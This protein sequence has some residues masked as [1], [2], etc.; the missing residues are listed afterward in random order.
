MKFKNFIQ[1][2]LNE[3]LDNISFRVKLDAKKRGLKHQSHNI[4]K[5]QVG[6]KFKWVEQTKKFELIQKKNVK[7]S[8]SKATELLGLTSPKTLQQNAELAKDK[9]SNMTPNTPLKYKVA[10]QIIIDAAK[11]TIKMNDRDVYRIVDLICDGINDSIEYEEEFDWANN[12]MDTP[13]GEK[14]TEIVIKNKYK[15]CDFNNDKFQNGLEKLVEKI[16]KQSRKCNKDDKIK[17]AKL[18]KEY[19]L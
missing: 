15:D 5:D 1:K 9:L 19:V 16:I 10:A 13:V 8:Y 11:K 3:E 17:I 14:I 4:W 18:L 6:N 12:V 7:M 2:K